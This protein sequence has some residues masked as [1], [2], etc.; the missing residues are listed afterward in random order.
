MLKRKK[1]LFSLMVVGLILTVWTLPSM[2]G[3]YDG[4]TITIIANSNPGSGLDLNCRFFAQN[5][6][7]HFPG[8]TKLI[9]KNMGAGMKGL[10]FVYEK[11]RPDGLT[12]YYGG[13]NPMG[14]LTG[15]PGIRFKL[16]ELDY[17]GGA[18]GF[19][20]TIARTDTVS[21]PSDIRKAK[22]IVI[23]GINPAISL[24]A[25][26][27]MSLDLLGVDYRYVT[28]FRG[29]PK[30]KTALLANEIQLSSSGYAGYRN[31]FRDTSLKSG[32]LT[33]MWYHPMSDEKGINPF[34]GARPFVDVYKELTGKELS[35]PLAEAYQYL[36]DLVFRLVNNVLT[37]PGTPAEAVAELRRTFKST[38]DDEAFQE[39]WE[40]Q[41]DT[42]F[43]W[44]DGKTGQKK[45]NAYK[46]VSPEAVDLFV[47][48]KLRGVKRGK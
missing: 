3:F 35:G 38:I 30:I 18:N 44:I 34:P 21:N 23:G 16:E 13:F 7:K 39:A 45:M 9:V 22:K 26:S 32:E 10:N 41:Y 4:K 12:V 11:A 1:I 17:I 33:I 40:K 19:F 42:R 28:G 15:Q 29:M 20:F 6:Q 24:D 46:Q 14:V 36:T 48:Y 47:K 31:F 25:I 8:K 2:A 5:W 27:Q 43:I 37:P